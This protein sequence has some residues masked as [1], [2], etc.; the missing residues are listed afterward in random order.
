MEELCIW[1]YLWLLRQEVTTRL[2]HSDKLNQDF[3]CWVVSG[4]SCSHT[5]KPIQ[6]CSNF[7]LSAPKQIFQLHARGRIFLLNLKFLRLSFMGPMGPNGTDRWAD[8]RTAPLSNLPPP[9]DGRPYNNLNFNE[10]YNELQAR[11][12]DERARQDYVGRMLLYAKSGCHRWTL[13][14]FSVS[15]AVIC[16]QTSSRMCY[17]HLLSVG[18]ATAT[19]WPGRQTH[20]PRYT[21]SNVHSSMHLLAVTSVHWSN[22]QVAWYQRN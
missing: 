8:G 17:C 10:S 12:G 22:G 19:D 16:A 21:L 11:I 4:K 3:C 14:Y 9:L 6:H 18:C 15:G 1:S 13:H 2:T 5:L 20:H 7:N